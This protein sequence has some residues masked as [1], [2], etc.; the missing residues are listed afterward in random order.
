[1]VEIYKLQTIETFSYIHLRAE[2]NAGT[3]GEMMLFFKKG[4]L[5]KGIE[6]KKKKKD[7]IV[8]LKS[9]KCPIGLHKYNNKCR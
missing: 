8:I 6:A 9:I 4:G 3:V 2:L 1:M 7:Y 5:I